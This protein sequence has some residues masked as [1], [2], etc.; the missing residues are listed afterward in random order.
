MVFS[1]IAAYKSKNRCFFIAVLD[2]GFFLSFGLNLTGFSFINFF[3]RNLDNFLI[4]K[5]LG[6][7]PL[8]FYNL[9]YRI[10]LFPLTKISSVIGR[11]MFP[12]LSAIQDDKSKVRHAY[13]AATRYIAVITFPLMI[14][15]LV[16]APQF[17]RVIFGTQWERTIL[18]VQILSLVGLTQSI[19]TTVGW[20]YQSQGRTDILFR[21]GIFS[22]LIVIIAFIIGL[23]WNIEGIAIAY[24]IVGLLLLYPNFA[25]PFRLINL[26]FNY[27]IKNFSSIFL[28]VFGMGLV[29]SGAKFFLSS[30]LLTNDVITLCLTVVIG[31]GSY[32]GLL[33]FL[34]KELYREIFELFKLLKPPTSILPLKKDLI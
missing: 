30:I 34:E 14:G 24:A 23:R 28:A 9:A 11:V 26:K 32:T 2:E 5:F 12:S 4:G 1:Q 15:L 10:L 33:F 31:I 7:V 21:W 25:I 16:V 20:I 3:S 18:L 22:T 27:F 6:S 19:V 13:L 29:V 8:G 17:I